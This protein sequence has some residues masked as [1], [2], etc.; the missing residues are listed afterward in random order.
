[1]MNPS[2][3][4]RIKKEIAIIQEKLPSYEVYLNE[5]QEGDKNATIEVITPNFNTL[6]FNIP[7]DFP[8]K[9]PMNLTLNGENYRQK[10]K[11]MPKRIQYLYDNPNDVYFQERSTIKHYK[12]PECLCCSTLLCADN[13]SPVCT[14]YRLLIEINDH[15]TLKRQI[16]YKLCLKS[17]CDKFGLP[18][19][20]LR[21]LFVFL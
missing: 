13:W 8:F 1:M 12:K 10:L 19:E 11:F 5:I 15:N 3:L 20:I 9:P 17:V 21:Y 4:R 16:S 6:V 7:N 14:V 2:A 18:N